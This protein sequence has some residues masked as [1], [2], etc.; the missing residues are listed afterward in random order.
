MA[1][2]PVAPSAGRPDTLAVYGRRGPRDPLGMEPSHL[3]NR[4][5]RIVDLV[6]ESV[7]HPLQAC[8]PLRRHGA[9]LGQMAARR[10]DQ[11]RPL[12]DEAPVGAE[13]IC[14]SLRPGALHR[15]EAHRRPHRCLRDCLRT[16]SVVPPTLHERLDVSRWHQ[17]DLGAGRLRDPAPGA[18]GRA[19]LDRHHAGGRLREQRRQTRSRQGTI[20]QNRPVRSHRADLEAALRQVD[21]QHAR[22]RRH[23]CALR[24][25][26]EEPSRHT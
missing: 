8:R 12:A 10:I 14:A 25:T 17:P 1:G 9:E 6:A 18:R 23:G 21:R 5:G 16:G 20:V 11:L 24:S 13:S 26:P 4:I 7:L 3:P 22:L 15:D 19:G 2:S